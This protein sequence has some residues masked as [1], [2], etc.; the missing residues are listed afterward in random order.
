MLPDGSRI[1]GPASMRPAQNIFCCS[2]SDLSTL[3]ILERVIPN[4]RSGQDRGA[5]S[6]TVGT[7]QS[8]YRSAFYRKI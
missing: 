6:G 7:E 2:A 1:I 4:G 8:E 5:F 3:K